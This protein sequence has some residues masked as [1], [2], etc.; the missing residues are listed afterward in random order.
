MSVLTSL[1]GSYLLSWGFQELRGRLLRPFPNTEKGDAYRGTA[2]NTG[3]AGAAGGAASAG[4]NLGGG[5]GDFAGGAG[6]GHGEAG[7]EGKGD[8]G[9]SH[10]G[11]FVVVVGE[12][13]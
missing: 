10:G 8:G 11:G 13:C 6:R 4:V 2:A 5:G 1:R 3:V 9:E 12:F 7:E